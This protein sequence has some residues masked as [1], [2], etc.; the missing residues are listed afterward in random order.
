MRKLIFLCYIVSTCVFAKPQVLKF[1][2]EDLT[3]AL[4]HKDLKIEATLS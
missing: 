2:Q 4:L 3:E 1:S